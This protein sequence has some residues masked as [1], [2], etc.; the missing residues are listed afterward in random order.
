MRG[1]SSELLI[2]DPYID[3][4]LIPKNERATFEQ[5]TGCDIISIHVHLAP[6]TLHLIDENFLSRCKPDMLMVNT[7]R[8]GIVDEHAM[9]DFLNKNNEAVYATDVLAD[10][11]STLSKNALLNFPNKSQM[12][13][14]PHIGGMTKESRALAYGRAAQLLKSNVQNLE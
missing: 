1:L 3:Q 12:I 7:S 8:G 13:I 2:H 14:T 10:E 9:I 11:L 6:D 4:E 5:I